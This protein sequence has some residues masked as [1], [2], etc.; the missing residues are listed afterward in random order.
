MGI[1]LDIVDKVVPRVLKRMEYEGTG[2]KEIL[3]EELQKEIG[4]TV[5]KEY[6]TTKNTLPKPSDR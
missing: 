6:D 5:K 2:L 1:L 3:E 4:Q